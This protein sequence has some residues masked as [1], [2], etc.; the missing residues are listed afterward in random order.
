MHSRVTCEASFSELAS[1]TRFVRRSHMSA[2]HYTSCTVSAMVDL[3]GFMSRACH[4]SQHVALIDRV[5]VQYKDTPHDT[6]IWAECQASSMQFTTQINFC[7]DISSNSLLKPI[8]H[9]PFIEH[10]VFDDVSPQ[11]NAQTRT[12]I[13]HSSGNQARTVISCALTCVHFLFEQISCN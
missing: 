3:V 7:H 4:L 8:I 13:N 6:S 1:R 5:F 10:F 2:L 12:A 9:R 11:L